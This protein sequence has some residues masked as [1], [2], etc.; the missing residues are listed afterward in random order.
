MSVGTDNRNK[1]SVVKEQQE[2]TACASNS[3]NSVRAGRQ[4]IQLNNAERT[5]LDKKLNHKEGRYTSSNYYM[6]MRTGER[7]RAMEAE[8]HMP[9]FTLGPQIAKSA[10]VY[11]FAMLLQNT[12]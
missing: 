7:W 2:V 9:V 12:L 10:T 3:V 11:Q 6:Q 5:G 1:M 4:R 8:G